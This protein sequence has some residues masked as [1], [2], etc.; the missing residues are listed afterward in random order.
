MIRL[1]TDGAFSPG[2]GGVV[3]CGWAFIAESKG[4]ALFE[5]A[6]AMDQGTNNRM[7][8]LAVIAALKWVKGW[9]GINYVVPQVISDSTYVVHGA[10][11]WLAG[12]KA[13]GWMLSSRAGMP[14][15]KPIKN[16][17]LWEELDTLIAELNPTWKWVRGHNGSIFNER[18]DR[19]ATNAARHGH[20][21]RRP[22][23]SANSGRS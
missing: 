12:W 10:E 11:R 15:R 6:Q 17:D 23:R 21:L 9:Q 13:R 2:R 19:L 5:A 3:R 1:W 8:L 20:T 16:R 7:E 14:A 22:L 4:T 18:A